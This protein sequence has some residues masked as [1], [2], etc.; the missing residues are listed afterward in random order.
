MALCCVL[1]ETAC[2][3]S[4]YTP[5]ARASLVHKLRL[6]SSSFI[7]ICD[8]LCNALQ[9]KPEL[10]DRL[11]ERKERGRA[12]FARAM[13]DHISNASACAITVCDSA[14][15]EGYKFGSRSGPPQ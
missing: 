9:G 13:D 14:D 11:A 2:T 3:A 5:R 10:K 6:S 8:A 1:R 4:R 12:A 7:I 15:T